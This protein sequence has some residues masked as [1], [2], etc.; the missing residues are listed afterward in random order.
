MQ[1]GWKVVVVGRSRLAHHMG[2]PSL[3]RIPITNREII[4]HNYTPFRKY[5]MAR[6]HSYL[7][8]RANRSPSILLKAY[9]WRFRVAFHMMRETVA[10][11]K[12]HIWA[13]NWAISLGTVLG[14]FGWLVDYRKLPATIRKCF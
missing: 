2:L 7:E 5:Y 4:V 12:G 8:T 11:Q 14:I 10:E 1:A 6:N 13:A 9:F 3:A